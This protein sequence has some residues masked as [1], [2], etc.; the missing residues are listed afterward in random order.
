LKFF[1]DKSIYEGNKI[2]LLLKSV[3]S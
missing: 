3:K 2:D 1:I